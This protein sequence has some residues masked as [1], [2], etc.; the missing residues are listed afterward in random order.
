M[1]KG[2]PLKSNR[3]GGE[4]MKRMTIKYL[5]EHCPARDGLRCEAHPEV[6]EMLCHIDID[7]TRPC[8]F[9]RV[10]IEEKEVK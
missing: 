4:K 10:E 9:V 3:K 6:P 1:L 7:P 2:R 5:P 8:E